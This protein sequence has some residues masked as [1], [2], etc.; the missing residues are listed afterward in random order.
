[1]EVERET[2]KQLHAIYVRKSI[3]IL[4]VL[5][6]TRTVRSTI[7]IPIVNICTMLLWKRLHAE[8]NKKNLLQNINSPNWNTFL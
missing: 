2:D 3:L 4:I 7:P 6:K 1:M 5:R 8:V